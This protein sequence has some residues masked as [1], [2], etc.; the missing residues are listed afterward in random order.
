MTDKPL[1]LIADDNANDRAAM[2]DAL[3]KAGYGVI[4]AIDSGSARRVAREHD[5]AVAIIDHFMTPH[6]GVEFARYMQLDKIN[7]PMYLVT[8]DDDSGLLAEASKLGFVGLLKKPVSSERLVSAVDRG[9]K[10]RRKSV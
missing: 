1:I 5:V 3:T 8:H 9:L 7:I 4:Q 6:D 10:L 2:A